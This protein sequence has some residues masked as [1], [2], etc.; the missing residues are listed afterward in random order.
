MLV[1]L[2]LALLRRGISQT[3]LANGIN[4]TPA[5]VSRLIRGHVKVRA[6]DRRKIASFLGLAEAQL[7]SPRKRRDRDGV[8]T[9]SA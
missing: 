5:H 4:R 7:F 1:R 8:R 3:S 9:R 6:R 2:K